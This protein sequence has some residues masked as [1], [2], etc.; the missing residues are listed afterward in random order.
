MVFVLDFV[1]VFFWFSLI[2]C[3]VQGACVE[4]VLDSVVVSLLRDPNRKFIFAEMVAWIPSFL[5][6]ICV[7]F[8]NN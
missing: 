4:N 6:M 5:M 1:G 2:S 8:S 3:L 7:A